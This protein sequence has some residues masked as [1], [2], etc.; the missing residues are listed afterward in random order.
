MEANGLKV[1]RNATCP[2][3][4]G[5]KFKR[6]CIDLH[7]ATASEKR[8]ADA[9]LKASGVHPGQRCCQFEPSGL[10]PRRHELEDTVKRM[11]EAEV[12]VLHVWDRDDLGGSRDEYEQSMEFLKCA[13]VRPL[14]GLDPWDHQVLLAQSSL[15]TLFGAGRWR[16]RPSSDLWDTAGEVVSIVRHELGVVDIMWGSAPEFAPVLPAVIAHQA[17]IAGDRTLVQFYKDGATTPAAP[18]IADIARAVGLRARELDA[19]TEATRAVYGD[20]SGLWTASALVRSLLHLVGGL[21]SRDGSEVRGD[22]TWLTFGGLWDEDRL[23]ISRLDLEPALLRDLEDSLSRSAGDI[24]RR[25][26][27]ALIDSCRSWPDFDAFA[28][29]WTQKTEKA[30][31]QKE[32]DFR[33]RQAERAA[34]KR[35][36]MR[37]VCRDGDVPAVLDARRRQSLALDACALRERELRERAAAIER[38]RAELDKRGAQALA[39]LR[40]AQCETAVVVARAPDEERLALLSAV[41]AD[42]GSW[43]ALAA[44]SVRPRSCAVGCVLPFP[45]RG[46]DDCRPGTASWAVGTAVV[47]AMRAWVNRVGGVASISMQHDALDETRSI[48]WLRG[49]SSGNGPRMQEGDQFADLVSDCGQRSEWPRGLKLSVYEVDAETLAGFPTPRPTSFGG[50]SAPSGVYD[51]GTAD[52]LV[53]A[54]AALGITPLQLFFYAAIGGDSIT[55]D[56]RMKDVVVKAARFLGVTVEYR[57]RNGEAEIGETTEATVSR[58]TRNVSPEAAIRALEKA[59]WRHDRT[60]GDHAILEKEGVARRISLPLARHHLLPGRVRGLLKESGLS[61]AA[62]AALL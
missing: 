7:E 13:G 34:R 54:C 29:E 3:G 23:A 55:V 10:R 48:V 40:A 15:D 47:T 25:E 18:L 45:G 50:P 9:A 19:L 52:P 60:S 39:D 43:V 8:R 11:R 24:R 4:S 33:R 5:K 2:C 30:Y 41:R 57:D 53:E 16:V 6:C 49:R 17:G 37:V 14:L 51:M 42:K 38:E 61:A 1:S 28:A 35:R 21:K 31:E 58:L 59:G 27:V 62:F 56:E 12:T 36:P 20:S 26:R 32:E 44:R 22:L 46:A